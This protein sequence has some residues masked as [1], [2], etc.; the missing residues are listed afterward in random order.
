MSR[1]AIYHVLVIR[2][3]LYNFVF[4][5]TDMSFSQEQ[6]VFIVEHCFASRSSLMKRGFGLVAT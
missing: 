1:S 5:V 2:C 4:C 6:R 3:L